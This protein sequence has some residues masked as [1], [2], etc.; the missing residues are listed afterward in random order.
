MLRNAVLQAA[1]A[2]EA[3]F[4]RS[5]FS[6]KCWASFNSW[7]RHESTT[8]V[9]E[10]TS[11]EA[12][13]GEGGSD[14]GKTNLCFRSHAWSE[15]TYSVERLPGFGTRTHEVIIAHGDRQS[16]SETSACQWPEFWSSTGPQLHTQART[17]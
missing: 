17:L 5:K 1:S 15:S 13:S 14:F 10:V 12:D 2:S 3:R 9:L 16:F 11:K 8:L 6:N 4:V 7:R